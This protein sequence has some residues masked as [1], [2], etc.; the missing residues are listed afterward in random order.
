MP[1]NII[2]IGAG[3]AGLMCGC[4]LLEG[5]HAVTIVEARDRIGGRIHT[6]YD[7]DFSKPVEAG[8][9]FVH[10]HQPLTAKLL[11]DAGRN[12]SRMQGRMY[13]LRKG[14]VMKGGFDDQWPVLMKKLRKLKTD[15][16]M[17][18]FLD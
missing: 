4:T 5:N 1:H 10:G 3:A 8:A 14:K 7:S 16:D 9:E 6:L 12:L 18:S 11:K 15:T 2:V 17:Q 13:Q